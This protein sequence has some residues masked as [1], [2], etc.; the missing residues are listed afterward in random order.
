MLRPAFLCILA[1][2]VAQVG[3]ADGPK[4]GGRS[5]AAET[6][7]RE[8]LAAATD[9]LAEVKLVQNDSRSAQIV[10]TNKA[11]RPL[12]LK[13]PATFAGVPVLAQVGMGNQGGIGANGN[14]A[15]FGQA[16]SPQVTGGGVNQAGMG[17]G[18]APGNGGMFGCWV[19]REVYGAHDPRWVRFRGWMRFQ[20]P[21]W[22]WDVYLA[23]GEETAAWLHGRPV[24]KWS[25]RQVMDLAIADFD[26]GDQEAGGQLRLADV[27]AG[28]TVMPGKMR[29][30][31]V[32][33]V[34]L[35]H[36]RPEPSQRVTYKLVALE[37]HS[38]DPK[39]AVVLEAL[40]RG[41]IPQKV[42][43]AAAWHVANGLTWERLAAEKI[44]HAGG[45]P[46]EPFFAPWE[47]QAAFRVVEAATKMTAGS[48]T[49]A[50]ATQA[51]R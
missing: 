30:V 47:L 41:E 9:G 50:S 15:G 46:D 51:T 19:A 22:L 34:C 42:A 4:K 24:A 36:G 37:S 44:D 38:K 3:A 7:V 21:E 1:S 18:G 48:P 11:D 13:M 40:G 49:S 43:Q 27:A 2:L 33:T 28:L 12:T 25:L 39:V 6:E 31:R 17:V 29:T 10:V 26:A 20:A 23:H 35:Q 8:L 32:P 16:G 5:L 45:D 14:M